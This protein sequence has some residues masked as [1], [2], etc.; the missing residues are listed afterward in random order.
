[1][2]HWPH[3]LSLHVTF[4]ERVRGQQRSL[5]QFLAAGRARCRLSRS[6]VLCSSC[7]SKVLTALAAA[8][9]RLRR[10]GSFFQ[11]LQTAGEGHP[12]TMIP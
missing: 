4:E 10:L 11:L 9:E 3:R 6:V 5:L 12:W 1:M 7:F 8:P 2:S